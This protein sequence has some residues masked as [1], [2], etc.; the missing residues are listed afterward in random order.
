VSRAADGD[1]SA[2]SEE[3]FPQQQSLLPKTSCACASVDAAKKKP[4]QPGRAVALLHC[5]AAMTVTK[6]GTKLFASNTKSTAV[7]IKARQKL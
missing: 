1:T 7:P 6:S 4:A 3:G 5:S 2:P